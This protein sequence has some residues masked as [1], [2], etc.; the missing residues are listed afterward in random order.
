MSFN[1]IQS[2]K[3]FIEY[4]HDSDVCIDNHYCFNLVIIL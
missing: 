3:W 1:V 2:T 4:F